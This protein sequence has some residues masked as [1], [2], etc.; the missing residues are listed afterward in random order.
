[1]LINGPDKL[2]S[3]PDIPQGVG[4]YD[5]PPPPH[6]GRGGGSRYSRGELAA[7]LSMLFLLLFNAFPPPH[8]ARLLQNPTAMSD[9]LQALPIKLPTSLPLLL[10]MP[11]VT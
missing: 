3:L 4:G 8:S 1:V 5:E 11:M 7:A 6:M 10:Q 9:Y 2:T